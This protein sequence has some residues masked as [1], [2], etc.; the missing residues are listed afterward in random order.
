MSILIKDAEMPKNC[1]ECRYPCKHYDCSL[2]EVPSNVELID[3]NAL[4]EKIAKLEAQALE[5]AS[6]LAR[7]GNMEEW[8]KWNTILNERTAFKYDV[9][10]T[11]TII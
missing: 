5:K 8:R 3:K 4:Y 7:A 6:T 2:V 10:D 1:A 9:V 11:P